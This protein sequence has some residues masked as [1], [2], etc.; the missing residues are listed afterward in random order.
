MR[1]KKYFTFYKTTYYFIVDLSAEI[2]DGIV[3]IR[4]NGSVPMSMC[5]DYYFVF[6]VCLRMCVI[7]L[8]LHW[9]FGLR[10]YNIQN[11]NDKDYHSHKF[12]NFD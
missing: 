12:F 10:F 4:N 9:A 11:V 1:I 8:L 6:K 7:H 5:A 2:I 3:T